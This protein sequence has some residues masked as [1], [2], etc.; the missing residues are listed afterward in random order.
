ME[1]EVASTGAGEGARAGT[2]AVSSE[3]EAS[4][5]SAAGGKVLASNPQVEQMNVCELP[6]E[7]SD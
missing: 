5:L 6:Q 2:G 7:T 3:V 4:G 1:G